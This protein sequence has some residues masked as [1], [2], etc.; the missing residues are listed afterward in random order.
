MTVCGT[1]RVMRSGQVASSHTEPIN[2]CVVS[3]G[4]SP[5]KKAQMYGL[6]AA[7]RVRVVVASQSSGGNMPR[8]SSDWLR[9][10]AEQGRRPR[11]VRAA[12]GRRRRPV[13]PGPYPG[14]RPA[15]TAKS[16]PDAEAFSAPSGTWTNRARRS[17]RNAGASPRITGRS[18]RHEGKAKSPPSAARQRYSACVARPALRARRS[19]AARAASRAAARRPSCSLE[20]VDARCRFAPAR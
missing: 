9:H 19:T 8:Q 15:G 17:R 13:R 2:E 6:T 10:S 1:D 11:L 12:T 5:P 20:R 7:G 18:P 14:T 4:I 3:R 16:D